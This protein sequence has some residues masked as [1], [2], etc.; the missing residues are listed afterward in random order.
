MAELAKMQNDPNF[1]IEFALGPPAS[2]LVDQTGAP[3]EL[4]LN[5][6]NRV[7]SEVTRYVLKSAHLSA[8]DL[9]MFD[10]K[11]GKLAFV[12]HHPGKNPYDSLDPLSLGNG[13]A[14]YQRNTMGEW[15]SVCDVRG[16]GGFRSFKVRPKK[17]S[18]HGRQYVRYGNEEEPLFNMSNVSRLKSQSIRHSTAACR[19]DER[20]PVWTLTA[21]MMERTMVVLNEKEEQVAFVQKS[22]KTLILNAQF[23]KGSEVVIDIAPGVDQFALLAVLFAEKQVGAHAVKDGVS[24]FIVNPLQNEAADQAVEAL[25]MGEAVNAYNSLSGGAVHYARVGQWVHKSFFS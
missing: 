13:D 1:I 11:T 5:F 24:N 25:G 10:V 14:A 20:E 17:L 12:S 8:D 18:R 21:D 6:Q 2:T 23:G 4:N 15:D 16:Y 3:P 7:S 19:G 9:R 22:L